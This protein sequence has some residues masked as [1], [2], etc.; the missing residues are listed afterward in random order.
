VAAEP[1][2]IVPRTTKDVER[3]LK[4]TMAWAKSVGL[5]LDYVKTLTTIN[6]CR[7]YKMVYL[8]PFTDEEMERRW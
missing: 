7:R 1:E 8:R 3:L 2:Q 5:T 6:D 4:Q